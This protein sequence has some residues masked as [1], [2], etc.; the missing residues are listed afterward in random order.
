MA[1]GLLGGARAR[2]STVASACLPMSFVLGPSFWETRDMALQLTQ[3]EDLYGHDGFA[4]RDA[5]D[6][7]NEFT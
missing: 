5:V 1:G 4:I 7:Q 6:L 3:G 2:E